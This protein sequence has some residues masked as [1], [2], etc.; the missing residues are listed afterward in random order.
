M[1]TTSFIARPP[2][3]PAGRAPRPETTVAASRTGIS[4][5]ISGRLD[6]AATRLMVPC[7]VHGPRV[8]APLVNW[9]GT[10]AGPP[11]RPA[12]SL[13]EPGVQA[14]STRLRRASPRAGTTGGET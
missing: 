14:R 2:Q 7:R 11:H 3:L 12:L 4:L 8:V 10:A 5:L 13:G 9:T 1:I 6:E